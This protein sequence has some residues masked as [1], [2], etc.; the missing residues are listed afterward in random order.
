MRIPIPVELRLTVSTVVVIVDVHIETHGHILSV[1]TNE[2]TLLNNK[3]HI[4]GLPVGCFGGLL[5]MLSQKGRAREFV[6][7]SSYATMAIGVVFLIVGILALALSQPYHVFYPLLLLGVILSVVMFGT[8]K[9][10]RANYQAAEERRM[11]A[12]D[13]I[14]S[15]AA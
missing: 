4:P 7:A 2:R 13:T 10:M 14:G 12:M 6:L 15:S 9:Q 11:A 3:F 1:A 5:G 8:R